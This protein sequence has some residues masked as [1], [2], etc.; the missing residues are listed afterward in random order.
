MDHQLTA[1]S[2]FVCTTYAF[3]FLVKAL[4][5]AR[6]RTLALRDG[7]SEA[8]IQ[9][10]AAA[11]HQ[12]RRWSALRWGIA[13]V[14]VALGFGLIQIVGWREVTPGVV[15][16]LAAAIGAGQLSFYFVSRS[17]RNFNGKPGNL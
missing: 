4:I 3:T 17:S 12:Q 2:L 13:L 6:M 7:A 11:E 8:L 9:A 10:L 14:T 15:A 5:D 1:I 16:V